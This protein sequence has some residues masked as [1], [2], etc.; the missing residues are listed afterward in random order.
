MKKLRELSCHNFFPAKNL[1]TLEVKEFLQEL[2]PDWT[3]DKEGR[4]V[5]EYR[6]G[7]YLQLLELVSMI[8]KIS[9]QENHHP[10]LFLSFK[11]LHISLTTHSL[12]ELSLA[13]F[14]LAAKIDEYLS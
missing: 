5:R 2:H 8:G 7:H 6:G 4:L 11:F 10:D 9:D 1:T 14:I 3:I 12:Q 13:D